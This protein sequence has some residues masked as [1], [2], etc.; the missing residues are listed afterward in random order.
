MR[1]HTLLTTAPAV[2]ATYPGPAGTARAPGPVPATGAALTVDPP[3]PH[4]N[5][6]GP[7]TGTDAVDETRVPRAGTP[8]RTPQEMPGGT[9]SRA[10]RITGSRLPS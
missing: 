5:T 7:R 3:G 1:R 4:R 8:S 9:T 6:P 10:L 2:L